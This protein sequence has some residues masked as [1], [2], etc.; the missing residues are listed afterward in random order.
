[1]YAVCKEAK[2]KENVEKFEQYRFSDLMKLWCLDANILTQED[3]LHRMENKNTYSWDLWPEDDWNLYMVHLLERTGF[4][5]EIIT[6][7]SY[8]LVLYFWFN[9]RNLTNDM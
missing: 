5:V 2:L 4:T 8:I 9:M 7:Y 6:P 1:M 3:G